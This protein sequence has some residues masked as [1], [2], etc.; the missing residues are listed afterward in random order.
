VRR[1]DAVYTIPTNGSY[2]GGVWC[3]KSPG[4]NGGYVWVGLCSAGGTTLQ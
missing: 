4:I 2:A 3:M 1:P